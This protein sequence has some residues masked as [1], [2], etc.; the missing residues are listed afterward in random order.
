MKPWETELK[1]VDPLFPLIFCSLRAIW[2]NIIKQGIGIHNLN[3]LSCC[4]KLHLKQRCKTVRIQQTWIP[5]SFSAYTLLFLS[6]SIG[7]PQAQVVHAL[8]SLGLHDIWKV[9]SSPFSSPNE[10]D[11]LPPWDQF[12]FHSTSFSPTIYKTWFPRVAIKAKKHMCHDFNLRRTRRWAT[13]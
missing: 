1:D 3:I 11:H 6:E 2:D 12:K 7:C 10:V 13:G 9:Q 5:F 8:V 4:K